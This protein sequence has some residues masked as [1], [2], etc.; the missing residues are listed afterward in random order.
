MSISNYKKR[1]YQLMESQ[2]GDVKP[3]ISENEI[4]EDDI[5]LSNTYLSKDEISKR[6]KETS[7][8][9][10]I[11]S[12]KV[13]DLTGKIFKDLETTTSEDY[14]SGLDFEQTYSNHYKVNFSSE[15]I[16]DFFSIPTSEVYKDLGPYGD[17]HGNQPVPLILKVDNQEYTIQELLKD[18]RINTEGYPTNRIHFGGG[19]GR[20]LEGTGLGYLIYQQFI[21]YLGHGS[22]MPNASNKAQVVWSKLAKD[23]DFYS[24][25]LEKGG[26]QSVYVISKTNSLET[27]ESIVLRLLKSDHDIKVILGSEIKKDFPEIEKMFLNPNE[28]VLKSFMKQLKSDIQFILEHENLQDLNDVLPNRIEEIS[29]KII[30]ILT[31]EN[32]PPYKLGKLIYNDVKELFDKF[33][34][35]YFV[36][37]TVDLNGEVSMNGIPYWKRKNK[38]GKQIKR[39]NFLSSE[40]DDGRPYH[41]NFEISIDLISKFFHQYFVYLEYTEKISSTFQ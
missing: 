14:V 31:S 27:P 30:N 9:E 23:P 20:Y 36:E 26:Y 16:E 28:T 39:E 15:F 13:V 29:S 22:S 33:V 3:I 24:F 17:E 11:K 18:I 25:I 8:S 7:Q 34:G 6:K 41:M 32:K 37:N 35:K 38:E 5:D 4:K 19:V 1:F 40:W 2:I 12:P 10:T 21:K